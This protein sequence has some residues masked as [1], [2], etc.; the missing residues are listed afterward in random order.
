MRKKNFLLPSISLL[1]RK[2]FFKYFWDWALYN[3]TKRTDTKPWEM[4]VPLETW[5]ALRANY[6]V[7]WRSLTTTK[8]NKTPNLPP[9]PKKTPLI[10]TILNFTKTLVP[11]VRL[12]LAKVLSLVVLWLFETNLKPDIMGFFLRL[13]DVTCYRLQP[14]KDEKP[15]KLSTPPPSISIVRMWQKRRVN[16]TMQQCEPA[17]S[18]TLS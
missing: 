3:V 4:L 17:L 5:R 1:F 9:L 7:Y 14:P 18:F 11:W 16:A 15:T 13:A 10:N 8:E 6:G 2:C 12:F